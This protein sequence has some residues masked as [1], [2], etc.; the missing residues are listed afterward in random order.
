MNRPGVELGQRL[1]QRC[2]DAMAKLL[3]VVG[4]LGV[5]VRSE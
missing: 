4:Q 2:L 3:G 1:L 5:V